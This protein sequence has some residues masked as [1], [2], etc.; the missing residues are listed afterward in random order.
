LRLFFSRAKALEKKLGIVLWQLP[1][2]YKVNTERL[3]KFLCLL[4]K[5]KVRNVFEFRDE[6]WLCQDVYK[7]LK[8]HN[9]AFCLADYPVFKKAPPLTANF[10]YIRRHG[11]GAELYGGNYSTKQLRRDAR[12]IRCWLKQKKDVY[13]YFNNDAHGYAVKNASKLKKILE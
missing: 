10:V 6:S 3:S 8:K 4:K 9:A 13:I 11:A 12:D 7:L 2:K 5:Y 1:P